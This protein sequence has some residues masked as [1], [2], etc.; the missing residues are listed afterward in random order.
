[1]ILEAERLGCVREVLVIAAALSLQDPRE[2][3]PSSRPRPTSCTP[4]SRTDDLGLPDLAEPLALPAR[5][6]ARAVQQRVPADVQAGVPQ[7]PAGPRVAGLRVPAA[8]GLQGDGASSVGQPGRRRPTP[9]ASTRPCCPG[10]SPTSACSRSARRTGRSA[11]AARP[12]EYLGARGARFAIFPGQR[13]ARQEPAVPDGRRAGR[14]QPAVG[15]AERRDQARV[16]RA[17]RR[18]PGQ[19]HATPSRTGRRSGPR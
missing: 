15:P 16:G 9:T 18:A 11:T 13:P 7:L 10:C 4:G 12:R 1:M 14:D 8:P 6:A 3:P 19:A 17:A 5:A 2:R